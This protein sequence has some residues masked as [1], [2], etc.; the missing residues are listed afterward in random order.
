ML[1]SYEGGDEKEQLRKEFQNGLK[2]IQNEAVSGASKF[3]SG[4][5]RSGVWPTSSSRL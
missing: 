5:G 2:A 4:E 3:A 1:A